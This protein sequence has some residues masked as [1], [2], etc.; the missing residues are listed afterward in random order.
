[1]WYE[2]THLWAGSEEWSTPPGPYLINIARGQISVLSPSE[3]FKTGL[4][5]AEER[6]L[7]SYLATLSDSI[8]TSDGDERQFT[9]TGMFC[10]NFFTCVQC[11]DHI[12]FYLLFIYC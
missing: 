6:H 11:N 12:F 2:E 4:V 10:C 9:A 5:S 7:L 3:T 1:M 8:P